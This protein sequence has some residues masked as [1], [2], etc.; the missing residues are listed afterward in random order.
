MHSTHINPREPVVATA[1]DPIDLSGLRLRNR[2]VMPG[3]GRARAFG[4]GNTATDSMV[5]Y[6]AQRAT[7]GLI[8]TE[9]SQPS[10]VGQGFP[11]T[12]GLHS[13]EQIAAWRHVTDAVHAEGGTIFAQISHVGRVGDPG[14]LPD[15]LVQVAPSA[16]AAPGQLFTFDGMK[17]FTTPRELT[18]QEVRETIADFAQAARNAIEAGFDGVELHA[19]YGYLIHQFLAPN[20][21]LRTDEW[22]GSVEGRVRFAAEVATAVSEAIGAQRT[23]IRVSPGTG[24]NGVEEP[25]PEPTYVHLV[26]RLSEIGL[27]Y[28]HVVE[29]SRDLTGILRKEFSGAFILNPATDGFTSAAELALIEDGTAD[30]ISFG[31]LFLAN[32]DLPA[33][34]RAGGPYNTPDR[35]TYYGGTDKGYIDYPYLTG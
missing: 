29:N 22:G 9:G 28:L 15:G 10:I 4:P 18:S 3:M 33:R 5:T 21:N 30:M 2:V 13:T 19:A 31:A 14:L 35:T 7:A 11:N 25:D 24:Y 27:A 6:Y 20:S 17:D 34:L 23:G 32:P 12:P 8:I 26:R 1:F 16:V